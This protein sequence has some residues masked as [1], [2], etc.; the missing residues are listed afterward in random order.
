MDRTLIIRY[1]QESDIQTLSEL[2]TQTYSDAFGHTFSEADLACHLE[3][4]LSPDC[5]SRTLAEDTVLLA[6]AADRLVGY[7]QF[8]A[9][10]TLSKN[11]K[12]RELRRL[13]VRSE[14]Q[15]AGY[16][17][18]LMEAALRHPLLREAANVYLDVWEHNHGAQRFYRR[19][20]FEVIG[21]RAFEVASGAETGRDLVM[22]RRPPPSG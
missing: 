13:Y 7:A 3:N 14:F 22:V 19:Y 5:F 9:A 15:N 4:N 2:A 8:G 17:T 20:G 10:K 21:A 16:G 12:D 1:A 18:S 6:E 11:E